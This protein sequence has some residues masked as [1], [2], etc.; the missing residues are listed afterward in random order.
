MNVGAVVGQAK[1]ASLGGSGFGESPRPFERNTD[2]AAIDH[3]GHDRL[4]R[5]FEFADS[6]IN[7]DRSAH[8]MSPGFSRDCSL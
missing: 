2:Y 1:V 5:D 4:V 7:L 8:A 3:V 6:R